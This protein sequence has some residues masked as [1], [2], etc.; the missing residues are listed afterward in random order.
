MNQV[1]SKEEV[2]ALF[3]G[4]L[5]AEADFAAQRGAA[6][7]AVTPPDQVSFGRHHFPRLQA[8][9]TWLTAIRG[10]G[11]RRTMGD[12]QHGSNVAGH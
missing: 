11:R 7:P 6:L 10:W 5:E 12:R 1:L 2:A 3:E 8:I 9:A 4:L